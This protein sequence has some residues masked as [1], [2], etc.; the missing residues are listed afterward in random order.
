MRQ[1]IIVTVRNLMGTEC[2]LPV[3]PK[4]QIRDIKYTLLRLYGLKPW[5]LTLPHRYVVLMNYLTLEEA[6]ISRGDTLT[7][8]VKVHAGPLRYASPSSSS[9]END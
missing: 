1:E 5:R 8:M 7:L 6:G 4:T 9:D 3:S 2:K